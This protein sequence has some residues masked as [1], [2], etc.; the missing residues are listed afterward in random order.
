MTKI[1]DEMVITFRRAAFDRQ[2]HEDGCP[3]GAGIR[4][5]LAAIAPMIRA[6]ALEEAAKVADQH[7]LKA[8]DAFNRRVHRARRGE[9][10]LELAAASGAG[11]SIVARKIATAIRAMKN[12]P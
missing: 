1:T 11:M 10:N 7:M 6:A 9:K 2:M 3:D 8:D 4:A 5:G 12:L